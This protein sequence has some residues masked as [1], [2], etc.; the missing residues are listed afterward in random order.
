[1][2]ALGKG[3]LTL[4]PNSEVVAARM[5]LDQPVGAE[6]KTGA[7]WFGPELGVHFTNHLFFGKGSGIGLF[8]PSL[9]FYNF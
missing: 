5:A 1:V 8:A 3:T 9:T 7:F 2:T 4:E 6:T